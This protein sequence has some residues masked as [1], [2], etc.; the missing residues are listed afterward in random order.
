MD[1]HDIHRIAETPEARSVAF[2]DLDVSKGGRVFDGYAGVYGQEADLGKFIEVML[3]PALRSGL[4]A[5][6]NVPML[7][8][9]NEAL[10]PFATTGAGTLKLSEDRRGLRVQ[11]EID[12]RHFL[13]PTL[14]SMMERG[15]VRGMSVG[16]ITG[17]GNNKV[18]YR[19]GR[20]YRAITGIKKLLDVS[21]TWDPAYRDTSAELRSLTQAFE[22]APV[23]IPEQLPDGES[24]SVEDGP[25]QETTEVATDT[26][27]CDTCGQALE[28]G[29]EHVCAPEAAAEQVAEES[30]EQR[31][32]A[33]ATF[34][35]VAHAA[36]TRRLQMLGLTLPR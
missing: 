30:E 17:R 35:E 10:P 31:S 27:T 6:P 22:T 5:S 33:E 29:A 15:E 3:P 28:A 23:L 9:H 14:M 16:M 24:Q 19:D 20:I 12:E 21:P 34:D 25:D 8:H 18:S 1:S 13:A 2:T 4:E 26:P 7:M 36:R 11:A 32:G